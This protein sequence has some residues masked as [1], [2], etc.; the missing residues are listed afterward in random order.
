M[1]DETIIWCQSLAS[2]HA[3]HPIKRFHGNR[4][5]ILI[6]WMSFEFT[7]LL[8]PLACFYL[9]LFPMRKAKF[10]FSQIVGIH[11]F[12]LLV[13]LQK[14]TFSEHYIHFTIVSVCDIQGASGAVNAIMLLDIFLF[15][16]ATLYLEFII[17]VPAILLVSLLHYCCVIGRGC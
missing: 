13:I 1:K 17:P 11:C 9:S 2:C 3:G 5:G 15:P 7:F 8:L 12:V 10:H 14:R 16:K 6:L 4:N